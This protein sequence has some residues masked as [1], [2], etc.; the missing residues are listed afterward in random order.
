MER[1]ERG[2][3]TYVEGAFTG[4]QAEVA[5]AEMARRCSTHAV[6]LVSYQYLGHRPETPRD[7]LDETTGE[8]GLMEERVA[9]EG[10]VVWVFIPVS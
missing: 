4:S 8:A 10:T 3:I 5:G 2:D 6:S 9:A 7:G 1:G